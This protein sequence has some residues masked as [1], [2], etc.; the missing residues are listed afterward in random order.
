MTSKKIINAY[1]K[2]LSALLTASALLTVISAVISSMNAISRR[3]FVHNFGWSE[4][5]CIYCVVTAVYL[6][7]PYL[8][9]HGLQICI[10]ILNNVVK[11]KTVLKTLYIIFGIADTV[12]FIL[13]F[14]YGLGAIKTAYASQ[15]VSEYIRMPKYILYT[16]AE[17]AFALP[18][19]SWLIVFICN[20]GDKV[21]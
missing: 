14:Y 16:I 2:V 20:K 5:T 19:V 13:L 6:A 8:E 3:V 17:V 15:I 1:D 9:L 11:N 10:D 4:E 18:I 7:I 21:E 12:V